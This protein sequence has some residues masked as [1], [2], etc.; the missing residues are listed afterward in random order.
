MP[1]NVSTPLRRCRVTDVTVFIAPRDPRHREALDVFQGQ[2]GY[3]LEDVLPASYWYVTMVDEKPAVC[4]TA[5]GWRAMSVLSSIRPE[6]LD[7]LLA[8]IAANNW[9]GVPACL[10]L[11]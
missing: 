6:A 10:A 2:W 8:E 4:I 3:R 11:P 5:Q 9:Y 7:A 1:G